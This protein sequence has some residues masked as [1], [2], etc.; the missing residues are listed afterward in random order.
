MRKASGN[1]VVLVPS[2]YLLNFL[3]CGRQKEKILDFVQ[4]QVIDLTWKVTG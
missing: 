2:L 3:L 4:N 1:T